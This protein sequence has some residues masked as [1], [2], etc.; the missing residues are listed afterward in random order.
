M[1][2]FSLMALFTRRAGVPFLCSAAWRAVLVALVFALWSVLSSPLRWKALAVDRD[3]MRLSVLYGLALALASSTFVGGYALT[4]VANTIFLHNL[5][6]VAAFPLAWWVFREKPS[7]TALSGGIL[8]LLGVGLLS[9]VSLFNVGHF[10]SSRFL[11]GDLLALLSAAGYAG[12][13]VLTRL[14]RLRNTPLLPTLTIAWAIAALIL[15]VVA[16]AAGQLAIGGTSLLWVLGLAVISTNLPFYL[17]NLGMREV[18]AGTTSVLANAEV[19]FATLLGWMVFGELPSPLGWLGGAIVVVGLAQALFAREESPSERP[20]PAES[21]LDPMARKAR[22]GRLGLL[23]LLFNVGALF[24]LVRGEPAGTLLVWIALLGMARLAQPLLSS[25]LGGRLPGLIR[26]GTALAGILLLLAIYLRGGWRETSA[27]DPILALVALGVVWADTRL[28]RLETLETRD[29]APLLRA[30][31][32]LLAGASLFGVLGHPAGLWLVAGSALLAL[33]FGWGLVQDS[34]LGRLPWITPPESSTTGR[35][36]SI[37]ERL[38]SPARVLALLGVLFLLG[39]LTK[40][41]VGHRGIVE[42]LGAPLDRLAEPG[43]LVRLPPPFERVI[44]VDVSGIRRLDLYEKGLPV[45]S[46]DHS[47]VSIQG[48]LHHRVS[49][50]YAFIF[51]HQDPEAALAMIVRSAIAAQAAHLSHDLLLTDGRRSLEQEVLKQSQVIADHL[52]LGVEIQAL[53]LSRVEVPAP[54]LASFLD[55]ITADEEKRTRINQAEAYAARILP[56]AYGQAV[57][58]ARGAEGEALRRTA[59]SQGD[60]ERMRAQHEGGALNLPATRLRLGMEHLEW[61]LAGQRLVLAPGDRRLWIDGQAPGLER[62]MRL[63]G[64]EPGTVEKKGASR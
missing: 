32:S 47:L 17:L 46:G 55:V 52:D 38:I 43:L 60:N 58:R 26:L 2:A 45:L 31:L 14:T 44:L 33:L 3:T 19:V 56:Q 11:L 62:A 54:V 36:E 22:L 15:V 61:A 24:S 59:R 53:H 63:G 51:Q 21:A 42:R 30:A 4:T 12:V 7:S 37:V 48:V 27:V 64:S 28:T 57:A 25:L 1:A 49:D 40:V 5:A 34:I 50:P 10:S 18:P 8:A 29:K 41:P 9:G 16:L 13:I 39:G 35:V 20:E 23:L 6:P